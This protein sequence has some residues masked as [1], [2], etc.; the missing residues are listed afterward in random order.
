MDRPVPGFPRI[1]INPAKLGGKPCVRGLRIAVADVLRALAAFP[2][3]GGLLSAYPDLEA[4]DVVEVLSFGAAMSDWEP[5][6]L[7][8][9]A[10]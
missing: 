2:E 6:L 1:T 4:D 3:H 9:S 10:A 5:V 8:G 7:G